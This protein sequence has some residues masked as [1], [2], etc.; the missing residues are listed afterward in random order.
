MGGRSTYGPL[1]RRRLRDDARFDEAAFSSTIRAADF[2]DGAGDDL[3]DRRRQPQTRCASR[4]RARDSRVN[5]TFGRAEG[6]GTTTTACPRVRAAVNAGGTKAIAPTCTCGPL[7]RV[8]LALAEGSKVLV[9][10]PDQAG[11][12]AMTEQRA[13]HSY[14]TTTKRTFLDMDGGVEAMRLVVNR[15]GR[16]GPWPR[17]RHFHNH[18][19]LYRHRCV[20]DRE[21]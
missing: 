13:T 12:C 3:D 11:G 21:R 5:V 17:Y 7:D 1:A 6:N 10:H 16:S 19:V 8:R 18:A 15:R 9:R 20:S 2:G 4:E 14:T